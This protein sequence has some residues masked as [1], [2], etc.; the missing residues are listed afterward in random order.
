MNWD[1]IDVGYELPALGLTLTGEG[2][3]RYALAARMPAGR[4]LSDEEAR[5]EGLPGQIIPGNMSLALFARLVAASFPGARLRRLSATFRGLV[6]P[7]RALVLSGV[8]TER[9]HLED[10]DVLECDLLLEN[11]EGDR[12]V[13]G[14]ASVGVPSAA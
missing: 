1:D 14:T 2:V 9:H 13:T 12:W 11:D 6:R 5:K 4:F 8:V 3:S 7:G 10:G